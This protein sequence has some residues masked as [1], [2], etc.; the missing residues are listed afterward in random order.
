MDEAETAQ[1]KSRG[2]KR[3]GAGRP[4][5]P[6]ESL[7]AARRRKET[8]LAD[9][10]QIEVRKRREELLEADAVQRGMQDD[11]RQVRAGMLAVPSRL[12]AKIPTLEPRVVQMLDAEIRRALTALGTG[13]E[14]SA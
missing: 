6:G 14:A 2:G 9:L 10:R 13:E 11:Y 4:R 1:P 8:A 3:P 7:E 12:R 5:A